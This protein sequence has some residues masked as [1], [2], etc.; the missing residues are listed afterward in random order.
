MK[1]L[2]ALEPT[3]CKLSTNMNQ[4][5]KL[6]LLL[7]LTAPLSAFGNW[8]SEE[9]FFNAEYYA[10]A[11][12]DLYRVYGTH[13]R[14]LKEHW[15]RHGI[16]EGR[17]SSPVLDVSWYIKQNPDLQQRFGRLSYRAA[18]NHWREHGIAEGRAAHPNF[19]PRW[20]VQQN[21]DVA[22]M[23][24]ANNYEAAIKHYLEHGLP[25]GRQ[26]APTAR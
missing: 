12:E 14:S 2:L 16:E 25:E 11:N 26:G 8:I 5:R 22:S 17:P 6:F 4:L 19:D 23:F 13:A 21:P 18:I 15:R 9:P 24:G 20:Y 3:Q 10:K 1:E 7:I